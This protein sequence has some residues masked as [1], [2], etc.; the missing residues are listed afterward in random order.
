MEYMGGLFAGGDSPLPTDYGS[1]SAPAVRLAPGGVYAAPQQAA[2]GARWAPA[3]PDQPR[4][5]APEFVIPGNNQY[6]YG[7]Q[8]SGPQS[9]NTGNYGA[10]VAAAGPVC[11]D[12]TNPAYAYQLRQDG[13]VVI[14]RS[15][16]PAGVGKVVLPN[17]RGH[18]DMKAVIDACTKG[19]PIDPRIAIAALRAAA[20]VTAAVLLPVGKAK[21]AKKA[22]KFDA[23]TV[24][25]IAPD[26]TGGFPTWVWVGGGLLA[27]LGVGG[28]L[29]VLMRKPA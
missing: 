4:F 2:Y 7:P 11:P 26:A 23:G 27:V 22:K 19:K 5:P 10:V 29:Y 14:V 3:S 16:F 1:A 21:K 15:K 6:T 25:T 28:A 24:A 8:R 13:A 20:D 12:P 18:A 17:T 9:P